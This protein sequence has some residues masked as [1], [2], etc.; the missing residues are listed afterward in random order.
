VVRLFVWNLN[1]EFVLF[2]GKFGRIL[3]VPFI[4]RQG[5][6]FL[7]AFYCEFSEK[8]NWST[9]WKFLASF[10]IKLVSCSVYFATEFT[11]YVGMDDFLN[12]FWYIIFLAL[13][14]KL[15]FWIE[16]LL[17]NNDGMVCSKLTTIFQ[18]AHWWNFFYKIFHY[19]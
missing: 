13:Q 19:F 5:I 12:I 11:M 3:C 14:V 9:K 6:S 17:I 10:I 2:S 1:P 4:W 16:L 8:H 7:V 18:I 15:L